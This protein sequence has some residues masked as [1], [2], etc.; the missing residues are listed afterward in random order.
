MIHGKGTLVTLDGETIGSYSTSLTFTTT[1][2]VQ[3]HTPIGARARV[4]KAGLTTGTVKLEG[5]YDHGSSASPGTLLHPLLGAAAVPLV[6]QPDGATAQT[7]NVVVTSYEESAPV[8]DM[9]TWACDM[10]FSGDNSSTAR[11]YGVG[12]YG[13]QGYGE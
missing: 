4:Y 6:Y 7:V 12:G 3:D 1:A 5:I 9:I 11:G 10:Q 8:A 2:D 13:V